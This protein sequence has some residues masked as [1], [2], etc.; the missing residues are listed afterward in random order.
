MKAPWL[1]G[2]PMLVRYKRG[3]HG[4]VGMNFSKCMTYGD[5]NA[6]GKLEGNA[7]YLLK[8]EINS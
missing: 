7:N 1:A 4:L 8:K 2:I 6:I 3:P 5:L